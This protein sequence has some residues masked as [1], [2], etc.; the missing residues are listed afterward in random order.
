MIK[1]ERTV[2]W[3]FRFH[4]YKIDFVKYM[5]FKTHLCFASGDL[6][7]NTKNFITTLGV[8]KLNLDDGLY[9]KKLIDSSKR[10]REN[11]PLKVKIQSTL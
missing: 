11:N 6:I 10:Q 8:R 2:Y 9:S 1:K 5:T 7:C 3:S 4:R